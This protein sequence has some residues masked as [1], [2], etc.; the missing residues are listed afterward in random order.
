MAEDEDARPV[1]EDN[2][3]LHTEEKEE[4]YQ[5]QATIE[6]NE[7]VKLT[8]EAIRNIIESD[9]LLRVLP[10][11]PTVE[12]IKAQCAVAQGQAIVVYL[13]RN[14]LPRLSIVVPPKKTTVLDLKNAIKRHTSLALK[15]EKVNKKISWKHV[16]KKYD[17]CYDDIVLDND[18]EE[19]E[20]Y[21]ICNKSTLRYK[22]K[23]KQ[24]N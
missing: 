24:K 20:N 22:K 4:Q 9:P 6:H 11:D 19:M 23:R 14:V 13:D 7:L 12:E 8:K 3:E 2:N 10:I 16:W 1:P 17:L 18:H 15:R 5:E 21:G